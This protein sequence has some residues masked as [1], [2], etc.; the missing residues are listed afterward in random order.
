[1][2][3]KTPIQSPLNSKVVALPES[4]QLDVLADLFERRQAV[5]HR[6]P[7]VSI[8]DAPDQEPVIAWLE[9]FIAEPP[10]RLIILTGEGVRR[11]VAAANRVGLEDA[12]LS[13]LASVCKICRGPKPGRVLKEL[14]LSADILAAEP[15]TAGIIITLKTLELTNS[16]ISVQLYGEDPNTPLM[17][18]L[19]ACQLRSCDSVAPY[20]Y[21]SNSDTEKVQALILQ[22]N[23]GAIDLIAFTSKSQISRLFAVAKKEGL[24]SE[25]QQGLSRTTTAAIGPVV[26]DELLRCGCEVQIMPNSSYFMKPLVRAAERMYATEME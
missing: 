16:R 23:L 2:P 15:T 5:V 24:K 17:D 11:L 12:F 18:Y 3:S 14:G 19:S 1:M 6:V 7:L 20:I 9:R 26:R 8:L 22:M 10:D 13:A 4:R 21:A 25:L